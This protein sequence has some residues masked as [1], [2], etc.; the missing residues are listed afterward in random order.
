MRSEK[1][2]VTIGS[3]PDGCQTPNSRHPSSLYRIYHVRLTAPLFTLHFA[4]RVPNNLQLEQGDARF[5]LAF[6]L[7]P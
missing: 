6:G 1:D 7:Y 5:S 2:T 4:R 3:G